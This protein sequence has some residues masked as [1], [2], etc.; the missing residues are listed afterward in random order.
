MGKVLGS[1]PRLSILFAILTTPVKVW[2]VLGA[3]ERLDS[4]VGWWWPRGIF[5]TPKR[6]TRTR[7]L[8]LAWKNT[9]HV[10]YAV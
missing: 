2:C 1:I 9:R 10:Q 3:W 6:R 4:I 8:R 5:G 7:K